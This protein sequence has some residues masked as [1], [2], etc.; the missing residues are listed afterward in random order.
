MKP[1]VLLLALAMAT[2]GCTRTRT[3]VET[4]VVS[5]AVPVPVY[6]PE[7]PALLRPSLPI[8]SLDSTATPGVTARAYVASIVALMGYVRELETLLNAY[9][10]SPLPDSTR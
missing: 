9:R 8:Q 1:L 7:P 2:S 3:V 10:R 4:Q 6:P 5:V